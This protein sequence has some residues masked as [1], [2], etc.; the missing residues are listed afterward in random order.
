M[1]GWVAELRRAR[2]GQGQGKRDWGL[3]QSHAH[4]TVH[5]GRRRH[6]MQHRMQESWGVGQ[7]RGWG[8]PVG[9]AT[10]VASEPVREHCPSPS[11]TV[12]CASRRCVGWVHAGAAMGGFFFG[13]ESWWGSGGNGNVAC[14]SSR[15]EV[16]P[17]VDRPLAPIFLNPDRPDVALVRDAESCAVAQHAKGQGQ[18]VLYRLND[19]TANAGRVWLR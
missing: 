11:V 14:I 9:G 1:A 17:A 18:R 2:A 10:S 8:N 3:N 6:R 5:S 13:D 19:A 15:G 16:C 4:F 12:G 7:P